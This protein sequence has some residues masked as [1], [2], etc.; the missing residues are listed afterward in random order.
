[1]TRSSLAPQEAGPEPPAHPLTE[2]EAV[3]GHM[4]SPRQPCGWNQT[5]T[6]KLDPP[7]LAGAAYRSGR[8]VSSGS[9]ARESHWRE[10]LA[11]AWNR[12]THAFEIENRNEKPCTDI[13]V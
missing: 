4:P 3:M 7:A 12:V 11:V 10:R 1:M 2:A 6:L 13:P 9:W 8:A 5:G